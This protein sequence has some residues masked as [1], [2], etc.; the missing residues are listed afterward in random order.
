MT[1]MTLMMCFCVC[2]QMLKWFKVEK[3]VVSAIPSLV[4]TWTKGF[5]F[6]GL[7]GDEKK[8]LEKSNLMV[9]PGT[10]WLEKPMYQK[11]EGIN[12]HQNMIFGVNQND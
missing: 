5:G 9:F 4:D 11:P 10:V 2:C 7:E 8:R 6:L 3:L 12:F 1:K